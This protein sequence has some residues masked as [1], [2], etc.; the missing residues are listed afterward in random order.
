MEVFLSSERHAQAVIDRYAAR[1]VNWQANPAAVTEVED[2]RKLLEPDDSHYLLYPPT[3][4][5]D[6]PR[7]PA[8]SPSPGDTSAEAYS[9]PAPTPSD[10]TDQN[11]ATVTVTMPK[12]EPKKS[13]AFPWWIVIG[14]VKKLYY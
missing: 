4:Y 7:A 1:G 2:A 3:P 11:G 10:E 9:T 13:M 8:T 6:T 14:A 12:E 5:S